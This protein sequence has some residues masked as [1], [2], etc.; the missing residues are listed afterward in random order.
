VDQR[1]DEGRFAVAMRVP[2]AVQAREPSRG[3]DFVDRRVVLDPGIAARHGAGVL[4]QL[5]GESRVDQ[6]GVARAG[7]V[8]DQ[9]DDRRDAQVLEHGQAFIGPR[10]VGG[11]DA[12]GCRALP[13][14]GVADGADAERSKT[15]QVLQP[16]GMAVAI[17]LGEVVI[18][19][20]VDGAFQAAPQ[21]ERRSCWLN[22]IVE[23]HERFLRF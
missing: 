18:A 9:A 5:L 19:Y 8:V 10:P 20:A 6:A 12:I 17:H 2:H 23:I 16:C 11:L 21:L 4:G 14:H 3:A 22:R 15:F 7:T 13:Q 1:A